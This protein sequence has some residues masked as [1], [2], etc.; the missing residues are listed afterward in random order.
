MG[1]AQGY[2]G[3]PAGQRSWRTATLRLMRL[4]QMLGFSRQVIKMA[5]EFAH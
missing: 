1:T 5:K 3:Q 4:P 2:E